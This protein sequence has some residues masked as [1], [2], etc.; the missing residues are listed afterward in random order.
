MK[1]VTDKEVEKYQKSYEAYVGAKSTKTFIDSL[2]IL[3]TRAV[4]MFLPIKNVEEQKM[5]H[6]KTLNSY[7]VAYKYTAEQNFTYT[8][9]AFKLY[10]QA[11]PDQNM[12]PPREPK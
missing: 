7:Q 4:G 6:D 8:S 5:N 1:Y 11:Y 10:N 2:V 3:T 9:Y 12:I